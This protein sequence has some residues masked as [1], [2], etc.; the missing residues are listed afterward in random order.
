MLF[1]GLL[2]RESPRLYHLR[3]V[4]HGVRL[5]NLNI[6]R[7]VKTFYWVPIQNNIMN[8]YVSVW[9]KRLRKL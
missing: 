2:P 8:K 5:T 7:L 4:G 9:F 6:W 1:Y 3:V